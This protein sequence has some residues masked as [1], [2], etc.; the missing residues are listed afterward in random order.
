MFP[1]S[2]PMMEKN[3]YTQTTYT[4]HGD[5]PIHPYSKYTRGEQGRRHLDGFLHFFLTLIMCWA[6]NSVFFI[7]VF[8]TIEIHPTP[9]G[10]YSGG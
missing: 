5:N 10:V 2:Y 7:C 9:Q 1:P 3:I 8:C 6:G 4:I